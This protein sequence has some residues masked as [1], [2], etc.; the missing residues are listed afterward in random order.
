MGLQAGYT[1]LQ[2]RGGGLHLLAHLHQLER[3]RR[4]LRHA[5]ARALAIARVRLRRPLVAVH[6]RLGLGLGLGVG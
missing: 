3:A 2:R 5:A 6:L 4:A 1:G